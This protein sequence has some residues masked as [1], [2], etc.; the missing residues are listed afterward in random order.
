MVTS[1]NSSSCLS[2]A[3]DGSGAGDKVSA[4][5]SCFRGMFDILYVNQSIQ[6]RNQRILSARLLSCLLMRR[7]TNG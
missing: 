5:F 2:L 6:S 4:V 1:A 3:V 7:G